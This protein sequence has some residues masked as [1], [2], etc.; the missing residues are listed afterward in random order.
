[1]L[2]CFDYTLQYGCGSFVVTFELTA[3]F[4]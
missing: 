4:N 1:L 2:Y 3:A